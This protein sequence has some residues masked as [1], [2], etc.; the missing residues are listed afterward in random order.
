MEKIS[1]NN[2]GKGVNLRSE[3]TGTASKL[4]VHKPAVNPKRIIVV[5]LIV[6]IALANTACIPGFFTLK[7]K[8]PHE[9]VVAALKKVND[10]KQQE[11]EA[12]FNFDIRS[13]NP[14]LQTIYNI[15]SQCV[16]NVNTKLD[17]ENKR[18]QVY[19]NIF[20]KDTDCGNFA[21]YGDFERLTLQS[22]FLGPK[23]FYFELKD[24]NRLAQEHFGLQLRIED[25]LPVL[26]EIDEKTRREIETAIWDF[27]TKYYQDKIT[28]GDQAVKLSVIENNREK[29]ITCKELL[30]QMD[31][32]AF[33]ETSEL[34]RIMLA[35]PALRTLIKDKI[36]QLLSIAQQNGDLATWPITAEEI[37]AFRDQLDATLDQ[38]LAGMLTGFTAAKT[39]IPQFFAFNGKILID[40]KGFWRQ[41]TA[42]HTMQMT[43][44]KTGEEVLFKV[45][46]K[47][48]LINPGQKLTFSPF[49]AA[50]AINVGRLSAQEWKNLS[51]EIS[52]N[53]LGQ[54]S[55]NPLF[56]DLIS[57]FIQ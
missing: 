27:Y 23:T 47:Q 17:K 43:E 20:Y 46:L 54:F 30:L 21:F 4:K 44:A 12:E 39:E 53:F 29:K 50:E 45:A 5:A 6:L 40:R 31:Q 25:Y 3:P 32:S 42:S 7:P 18:C 52:R 2:E 15:F 51:Q 22:V 56:Q 36:T 10:L 35:N 49:P 57:L 33:E 19:W 24:L 55:S 8:P 14:N 38:L 11:Y 34:F 28:A 37:L 26:F 13:E 41:M 48:S 9:E 1:E 16:F